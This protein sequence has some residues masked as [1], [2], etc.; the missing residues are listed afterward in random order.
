MASA[1][2]TK[3][4]VCVIVKSI[5]GFSSSII[6]KEHTQEGYL[7]ITSIS[8]VILGHFSI[9][10]QRLKAFLYLKIISIRVSFPCGERDASA[11]S[12]E[13]SKIFHLSGVCK[14]HYLLTKGMC[15]EFN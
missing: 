11:R 15:Q 12:M 8:I 14:S 13:C 7:S 6:G 3:C 2:W 5:I 9:S 1:F 4:L 10:S